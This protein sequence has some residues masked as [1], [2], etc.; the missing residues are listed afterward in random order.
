LEVH[1]S[2]LKC[3]GSNCD[4]DVHH[5][6]CKIESADCT[7]VNAAFLFLE[8]G[9]KLNGLN[10]RCPRDGTRGEDGTKSVKSYGVNEIKS[11][12]GTTGY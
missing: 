1:D 10:F 6:I 11:Q 9:Y 3:H 2:V 8:S 5:V 4:A 7:S 12:S